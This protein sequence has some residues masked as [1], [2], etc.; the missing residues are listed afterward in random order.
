MSKYLP[1]DNNIFIQNR[2]RFTSKMQPNSIA[3]FVSND[4]FPLNG[5]ALHHYQQNSD[6]F[7]LSGIEQEGSMVILFPNNPDPKYREVLVLT[8]PQELKEIWD[9]KRLRANEAT[10]ISGMKTIVWSDVLDGMLQ[11]WIHL[12][13]SI[14]LDSNENDRKNNLVRTNEYRFIDEMQSRYPLHQYLRAAKILKDLRGIKTKEEVQVIQK[15]IDIT[16]VAF[17]RLLKFI[18]PGVYEYEIEAEIFHSFLSQRAPGPAYHSILASG[19][20]ARTLHYVSNNNQ[21]KDGELILMDFGAAYGG[22]NADLTRTVPVNGKFTKRQKEVYNACLHLHDYA[23]SILKPGISVLK[24]TDKVAEE[25]TKQ[26]LKIG[27]LSKSD[28]KNEDAE[29]RAYRKYLYHGISHHLGIDVHDLG[30]RT[31]PIQAGMVFTVE[32]GIYI[33]EEKM[34]VR[35]ENNIWITKTGNQDLFKNIPVKADEIEALMKK[36]KK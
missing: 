30:T 3:I 28:I 35:I 11:Q 2:K 14:Y 32:P 13:D 33:K 27:L 7:W 24:Y 17:R 19:D 25:A 1:L 20:N 16:E 4:E 6:L 18:Q 22:Y 8:R 21:C 31:E 9:G 12:A 15:A 29:N 36:T 34:G 10:A 26:F 5:D 23:K